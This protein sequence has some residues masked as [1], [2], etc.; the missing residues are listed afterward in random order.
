MENKNNARKT[1]ADFQKEWKE[2][3]TTLDEN[4]IEIDNYL[5]KHPDAMYYVNTCY[6]HNFLAELR[7]C[8]S[9]L[10]QAKSP[11]LSSAEKKMEEVCKKA[12]ICRA[13]HI[14]KKFIL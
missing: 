5:V 4:G 2:I 9:I 6:I 3:V 14:K 7:A 1:I 8:A 10:D 13:E 12:E 11:L